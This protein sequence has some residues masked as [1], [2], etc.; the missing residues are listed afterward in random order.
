MKL[1]QCESMLIHFLLPVFVLFFSVS[2]EAIYNIKTN[3]EGLPDKVENKHWL[4]VAQGCHSCSEVL[5]ELKT[6]CSSRKPSPSQIG[7]FATGPSAKA[8]LKKLEDFKA[9]YEIF[10]GSPNE[11]YETY[12]IMGS[13]SLKIKSKSK[14]VSGKNK[15]LKFLKKDSHICAV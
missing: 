4:L 10:S 1:G 8:L 5:M 6:F 14:S 13:P 9:D 7:F 3:T 2:S 12:K 11:F 15:I